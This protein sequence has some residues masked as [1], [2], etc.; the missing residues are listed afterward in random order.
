MS[1]KVELDMDEFR[2]AV[3]RGKWNLAKQRARQQI[4]PKPEDND[5]TYVP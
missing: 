3:A 5:P 1:D 4:R 2:G